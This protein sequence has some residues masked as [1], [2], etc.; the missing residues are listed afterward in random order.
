LGGFVKH[1]AERGGGTG[2]GGSG[3]IYPEG[4]LKHRWGRERWVGAAWD[5]EAPTGGWQ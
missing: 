5:F 3:W 4:N 1:L 2:T